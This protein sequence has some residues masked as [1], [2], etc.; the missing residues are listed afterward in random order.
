MPSP[1]T[2]VSLLPSDVDE[3]GRLEHRHVLD[4]AVLA[5]KLDSLRCYATQIPPLEDVFGPIVTP[6][7]MRLE[8]WWEPIAARPSRR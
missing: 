1:P 4:D 6:E 8:V 5:D 2:A 7:A 3:R